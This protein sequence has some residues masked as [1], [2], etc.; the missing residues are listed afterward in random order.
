MCKPG[1]FGCLLPAPV[2]IIPWLTVAIDDSNKRKI[3]ESRER[4]TV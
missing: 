3:L 2:C 1:D 4:A